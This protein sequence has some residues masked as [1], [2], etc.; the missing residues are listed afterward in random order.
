MAS[1]FGCS[2]DRRQRTVVDV[3]AHQNHVD[4]FR[5]HDVDQVV[6]E[7]HN[8]VAPHPPTQH[9]P[10]RLVKADDT[11]TFYVG[12]GEAGMRAADVGNGDLPHVLS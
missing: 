5:A 7:S 6:D 4:E 8:T 12:Q 11:P 9:H 10:T 1:S 2:P 3:A